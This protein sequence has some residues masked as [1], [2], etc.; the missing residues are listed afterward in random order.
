[1][2]FFAIISTLESVHVSWLDHHEFAMGAC[3]LRINRHHKR[4]WGLGSTL[5]VFGLP[6]LRLGAMPEPSA[7]FMLMVTVMGGHLAL[8]HVF[9]WLLQALFGT[10]K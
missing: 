1:M 3:N 10:G 9:C 5:W 2:D 4:L 6:G 7:T 8:V